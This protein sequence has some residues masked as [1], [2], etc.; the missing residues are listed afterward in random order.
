MAGNLMFRSSLIRNKEV[1]I[2]FFNMKE[3]VL[4]CIFTW[5]GLFSVTASANATPLPA[6]ADLAAITARGRMLAEYDMAA[7]QATDAFIATGPKTASSARYVAHLTQEGWVVDFGHLDIAKDK[8]LVTYEAKQVAGPKHFDVKSFSPAR[9]DEGWNLFAARGIEA[10][11]NDFGQTERP[12]NIAVLPKSSG[13]LYVYLYPAAVKAN[14]YPLGADVRYLLTPNGTKIIEKR[15]MH[16]TILEYAPPADR[17]QSITGG[18]HT[19]ILSDLPEDTDVML[20]LMRQPRVSETVGAGEYIFTIATDGTI[21]VA[22]R[23][24]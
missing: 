6:A 17:L 15:Q 19:H 24:K 20:V 22:G 21:M 13:G 2:S 4:I 18:Y 5:A 12:Y 11:I 7:W 14:V 16:K 10:A 9:Q 8:F 3:R 23:P 1:F